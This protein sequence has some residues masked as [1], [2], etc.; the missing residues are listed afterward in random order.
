M[1]SFFAT[2]KL[3]LVKL[4]LVLSVLVALYYHDW[5]EVS[6]GYF[7]FLLVIF[8]VLIIM[9]F[10]CIVQ[11]VNK[12]LS[13]FLFLYSPILGFMCSVPLVLLV[14]DYLSFKFVDDQSFDRFIIYMILT[15]IN[16][17]ILFLHMLIGMDERKLSFKETTRIPI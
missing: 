13:N 3:D 16:G 1:K 7:R 2:T 5:P 8:S 4:F 17:V 11:Y 14:L 12:G 10:S 9:I 15:M 6:M